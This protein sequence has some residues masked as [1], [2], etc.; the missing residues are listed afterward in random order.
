MTFH[1]WSPF[2]FCL[3]FFG[4]LNFI[5]YYIRQTISSFAFIDW[6]AG[7]CLHHL[8]QKIIYSISFASRSPPHHRFSVGIL[9]VRLPIRPGGS[10]FS[11]VGRQFHRAVLFT[12]TRRTTASL[13]HFQYFVN[14]KTLKLFIYNT[15]ILYGVEL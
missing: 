14:R 2:K 8:S 12:N 10:T 4:I 5:P 6:L 7:S 3:L 9:S 15:Y 11:Q 1:S 13:S